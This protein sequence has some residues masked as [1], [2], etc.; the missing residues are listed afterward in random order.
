MF[1]IGNDIFQSPRKL[2]LER[3][4]TNLAI[5][6]GTNAAGKI[7]TGVGVNKQLKRCTKLL[8]DQFAKYINFKVC[9]KNVEVPGNG[10][11]TIDM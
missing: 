1:F 7:K 9:L 5:M 2:F 8:S 6:P 4:L 10:Q 11:V 3:P